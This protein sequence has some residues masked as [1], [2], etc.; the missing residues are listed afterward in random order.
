MRD[1]RGEFRDDWTGGLI[2]EGA[3]H[4]TAAQVVVRAHPGWLYRLRMQPIRMAFN[5]YTGYG[6]TSE[7]WAEGEV[8]RESNKPCKSDKN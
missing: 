5:K 2:L 4:M 7:S 1:A 6:G 8:Q 3:T